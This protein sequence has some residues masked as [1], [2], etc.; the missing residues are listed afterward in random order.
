MISRPRLAVKATE[1]QARDSSLD[2]V[3]SI[4]AKTVSR[5]D[6]SKLYLELHTGESRKEM[7]VGSPPR[8]LH[9]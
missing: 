7:G 9:S 4:K 3:I 1:R 2:V 8:N 6:V 5:W